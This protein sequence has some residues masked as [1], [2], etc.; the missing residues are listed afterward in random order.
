M[1]FWIFSSCK[2][3]FRFRIYFIS[4]ELESWNCEYRTIGDVPLFPYEFIF[5]VMS[6]SDDCNIRRS[7][8]RDSIQI[9]GSGDSYPV[10]RSKD[11]SIVGHKSGIRSHGLFRRELIYHCDRS[12][13]IFYCIHI[14]C[15]DTEFHLWWY[16]CRN[17]SHLENIFPVEGRL[18]YRWKYHIRGDRFYRDFWTYRDNRSRYS[19]IENKEEEWEWHDETKN[20]E[21]K[22]CILDTIFRLIYQAWLSFYEENDIFKK[23]SYFIE[24]ILPC[25]KIMSKQ[26]RMFLRILFL[27]LSGRTRVRYFNAKSRSDIRDTGISWK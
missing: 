24:E 6:I 1:Q 16:E 2:S 14:E 8:T 15:R 3:P 23:L 20:H 21:Y 12:L 7:R 22:I 25:S 27:E 17:I 5:L 13:W 9:S 19:K 26:I 10:N 4:V 18:F 11:E